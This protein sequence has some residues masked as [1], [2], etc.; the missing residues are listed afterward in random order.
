MALVLLRAVLQ[1]H[2]GDIWVASSFGGYISVHEQQADKTLVLTEVIQVGE[3]DMNLSDYY[4]TTHTNYSGQLVDNLGLSLDGS[5]I[6]A[7]VPKALQFL[8][9]GGAKNTS[10]TAPAGAYRISINTGHTSYFGDKYK[11]EKVGCS[12]H[13]STFP[14]HP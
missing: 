3:S 12:S 2:S 5:I 14:T 7:T 13:L 8:Q 1:T 6:A 11:I 4:S 9:S 10:I